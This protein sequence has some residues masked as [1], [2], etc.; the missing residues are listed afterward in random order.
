MTLMM[1]DLVIA[2]AATR[3]LDLT[4]RDLVVPRSWVTSRE[5]SGLRRTLASTSSRTSAPRASRRQSRLG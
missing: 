3:D 5:R 1:G 2:G 4:R